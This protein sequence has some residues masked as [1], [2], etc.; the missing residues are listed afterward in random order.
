MTASGRVVVSAGEGILFILLLLVWSV[1]LRLSLCDFYE[2]FCLSMMLNC[3]FCQKLFGGVPVQLQHRIHPLRFKF[4]FWFV[5]CLNTL[6]ALFRITKND[7]SALRFT[8]LPFDWLFYF[9]SCS[10]RALTSPAF[11]FWPGVQIPTFRTATPCLFHP[12]SKV[13]ENALKCLHSKQCL[14]AHPLTLLILS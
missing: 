8:C 13:T 4:Q 5:S 11:F 2:I 14:F 6:F 9:L 10:L 12:L 7:K 3:C 1:S